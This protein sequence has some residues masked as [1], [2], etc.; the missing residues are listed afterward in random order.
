[1]VPAGADGQVARGAR[2][3]ALVAA[4]GELAIRLGVL[5]WAFGDA[6]K[7]AGDAFAQWMQGRG[8]SGSAED[9]EAIAKFGAFSKCMAVPALRQSSPSIASPARSIASGS[10]AMAKLAGFLVT[11]ETW[12]TEVCAGMDA[13]RVA[14]VLAGHDLLRKDSKGRNSIT[15]TLPGI[16]KARCYDQFPHL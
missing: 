16:G 7:A 15:V 13:N 2:R 3:F 11:P 4:A 6:K 12:R 10:G 5:P 8:G 9:R 14:K 1:M